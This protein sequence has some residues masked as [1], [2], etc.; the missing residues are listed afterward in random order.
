[1]KT[2]NILFK[3][4]Q[5]FLSYILFFISLFVLCE[6]QL[7]ATWSG[8]APQVVYPVGSN[9][10]SAVLG[11][12]NRDGSLDIAVVNSFDNTITV[13][14][15]NGQGVFIVT[16]TYSVGARPISIVT[17]DFNG[18]GILDLAVLNA[19]DN[20]ISILFG[21]PDGTF[22]PPSTIP[23]SDFSSFLATGDFN[24]DHIPDLAVSY[25][26]TSTDP[27]SVE[28]LVGDGVGN[29]TPASFSSVGT[30][31]SSI[32]VADF[33][34]DNILDMAVANSGSN[35]VSVLI[36]NN[37]GTFQPATSYSVG[38]LPTSVAAGSLNGTNGFID[39]IIANFTDSTVSVL[40]GNGDGTFSPQVTHNV[41][42]APACVALADISGSGNLDIATANNGSNNLTVL[43]HGNYDTQDNFP[44]GNSPSY[45]VLGDL[46]NDG[47]IDAV[48]TNA[49]DNSISVL[50]NKFAQTITF[51]QIPPQVYGNPPFVLNATAS[52]GLSVVFSVVS[53]PATISGNIITL[54]G[55]GLVTVAANQPGNDIYRPASQV[56]QSF[57]VTTNFFGKVVKNRFLTQTEYV[58][59]LTWLPSSD[60]NVKVFTILRN[61]VQIAEFPATGPFLFNDH[62]RSKKEVDVYTLQG[63]NAAGIPLYV[64]TIRV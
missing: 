28:V 13:L 27:N 45:V 39:L 56:I 60:P 10:V 51:P 47:F 36:G 3:Q 24:G 23:I 4:A 11:D 7:H 19:D 61:G 41:G 25:Q 35:D 58:H 30:D 48:V 9:P 20:T 2:M 5:T 43:V 8:F 59:Q 6:M 32:A 44:V 33:T 18:D 64:S 29:F 1:M 31:P 49:N 37:D 63:K 54:T 15:N 57:T 46:N 17:A 40:E 53:G 55:S 42:N 26:S 21:N 52:S 62:G 34:G 50:F 12:F 38:S 16:A 22:Q 14:Y